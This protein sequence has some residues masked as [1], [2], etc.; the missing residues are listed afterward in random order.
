MEGKLSLVAAFDDLIRCA[1]VLNTGCEAEFRSF[2]LN[3]EDN[4]RKWLSAEQKTDSN[5]DKI[6]R[7]QSEKS[8]LETQVKHAR[9]QVQYELTR[10]NEVEQERSSLERQLDVIRELL[11]DKNSKSQL[12]EVDRERLHTLYNSYVRTADK[13]PTGKLNTINESSAS[14]LSDNDISYDKTEDDLDASRLRSGR[15]WKRPSAPPL[16]DFDDHHGDTPPKRSREDLDNS[17]I[18]TTTITVDHLGKPVTA[19]TEV[20]VPKQKLNKSFSEPALDKY[21]NPSGEGADS[22]DEVWVTQGN[23]NNNRSKAKNLKKGILKK[24]P[25]SPGLRKASSAGRGLNRVHVFIS[26]TVIKPTVCVPCGKNIRFGK[27]AMKCKDCRASCHPECKEKL[28]LPCIPSAPSTPGTNRLT[29]GILA[30]FAPAERPMIPRLVVNCANEIER[31]GLSEVGLYR[32]PGSDR[33]SKELK[34]KFLKG[35][36]PNLSNFTDV[37]SVCGCLKDFLRNLKEPLVTFALWPQ[38]VRAAEHTSP[39]MSRDI[40]C[41]AVNCLPTANR[42]TLAFLVQH[43]QKVALS[44]ETRMPIGNLAKVFGPTLIGYS[45]PEPEPM[46]MISETRK[47]AMV[48]ENLLQLETDFWCDILDVEDMSLYPA[49]MPCTPDSPGRTVLRSRLGPVLTPGTYEKYTKSPWSEK[50]SHTPRYLSKTVEPRKTNR[51]FSSPFAN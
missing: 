21:G 47:Q 42:D 4:R 20:T 9:N 48:M 14:M 5:E 41:E 36:S 7:L 33:E 23:L 22:D 17:I 10:R 49:D 25:E 46:Q 44:P 50:M 38:F 31:R 16:D 6:K 30:D 35:K 34:E 43:L 40:L 45:C 24:T 27:V 19:C 1:T 12:H 51:L 37:H 2:V 29:E 3:Q 26:R 15:K 8:T 32:V 13:S 11:M 28:P 39:Q 18:T